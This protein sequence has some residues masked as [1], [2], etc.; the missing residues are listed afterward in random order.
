MHRKYVVGIWVLMLFLTGSLTVPVY[1]N[2]VRAI[3]KEEVFAF[4]RQWGAGIVEI[5]RAF[6]SGEDYKAAAR[7]MIAHM[8]GYD[9]GPVLFKPTKAAADQFRE[10]ADQALSYFVGG[11]VP[12]DHG[13]AL[14]PWS[15]VRFEN[16]DIVIQDGMAMAMGNYYFTDVG[17][18]KTVKVEY[19]LGI[20]RTS[21]DGQP[22][23]F[24]HHSSLP[25][26]PGD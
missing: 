11:D 12:E 20:R 17:T 19:T 15:T 25:F 2:T 8:Y 4:Q 10:T 22:V 24:L 21:A 18:G 1:G 3:T 23:I 7:Q 14:Q 13:F 9:D 6:Q 26:R 5:G 16:H